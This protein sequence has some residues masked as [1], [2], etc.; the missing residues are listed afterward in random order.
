MAV[1]ESQPWCTR[2]SEA[3]GEPIAG[4][5]AAR[6]DAW[7]LLEY[8]G[9]WAS[10]AWESAEVSPAVRT[11]VDAWA[12]ATTGSR[13]QLVRRRAE[14]Q[15][16]ALYLVSSRQSR[17]L[18]ARFEL[19][20]HDAIVALDLVAA[21]AAL[22]AGTLPG[23]AEPLARPLVL[24]CTNGKRDRCCAKWGL[25]VYD[26]I[27]ER[28]DIDAWQTTHL[29]G[30]RFAATLVWLPEGLC[31]GRVTPQGIDA[32]V[33]A[34]LRREIDPL[35]CLR[36]RT[37]L[38]EAAQAAECAWRLEHGALGFDDVVVERDEQ[39]GDHG[40]I[41]AS[42]RGSRVQLHMHAQATGASA[43]PSCG[44]PIEAIVAWRGVTG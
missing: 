29:G 13:I 17:P 20:D 10:K 31:F 4:T 41:E 35:S 3:A 40:E 15:G 6:V 14:S 19:A 23:G 24:V 32:L 42:V 12:R 18:A 34:G 7:L 9:A 2:A 28:P 43:P 33:D 44:K 1:D 21:T 36:G 8:R 25:P 27:A 37:A 30:H 39:Q 5:A 22:R 16:L 38:S 26:A 11:H